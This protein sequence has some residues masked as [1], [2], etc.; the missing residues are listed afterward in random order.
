LD[1]V[2]VMISGVGGRPGPWLVK[3]RK[4]RV[5]ISRLNRRLARCTIPIE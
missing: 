5:Y 4:K 3:L 2:G 1:F